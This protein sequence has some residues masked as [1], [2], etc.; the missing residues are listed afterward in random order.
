MIDGATKWHK[1]WR[2]N[3]WLT[4]DG[5]P[6]RT[7]T[8]GRRSSRSFSPRRSL[9]PRQGHSGH[10]FND[11]VDALCTEALNTVHAL[12]MQGKTVPLDVNNVYAA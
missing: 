5:K 2:R 8:C 10:E 9:R 11:H 4:A 7:V 12:Y 3:G 6:V 1:N